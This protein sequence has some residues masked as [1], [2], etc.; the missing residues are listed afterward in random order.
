[1][2]EGENIFPYFLLADELTFSILSR[3]LTIESGIIYGI[4]YMLRFDVTI[5]DGK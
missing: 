2:F 5:A 4:S 1:M 3:S